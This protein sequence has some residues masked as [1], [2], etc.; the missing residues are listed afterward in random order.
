MLGNKFASDILERIRKIINA[1]IQVNCQV[2]LCRGINDGKELD[3][4]I[5]DLSE[6]YPGINSISIVPVGITR[7]RENLFK[8]EPYD[9]EAALGVIAQVEAWQNKL[10]ETKGSRVVYLADEFYILAGSELPGYDEYE[11]FPQLEN[12]VGLVTLF[13]HEFFMRLDK[14]MHKEKDSNENKEE[15]ED[16]NKEENRKKQ[17]LKPELPSA[18]GNFHRVLSVATGVLARK[19]IKE[20]AQELERIYNSVKI[21]VYPIKCS[22]FGEHVTV[23]GLLT[24][25]DIVKELSGKDLGREL[26][27]PATTLKSGSQVF[28]DDYTVKQ[29]ED[30]LG[31]R[32][33]VIEPN[34]KS[35]IDA[36]LGICTNI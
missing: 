17:E 19:F 15:N 18:P 14:M 31:I 8:L 32:V 11:G 20:L 22:F 30:M 26:L 34:G 10:L 24:G 16:G 21:N 35:F 29:V 9:R 25:Q 7:Y 4:T 3:N 28:L 1:G 27:I 36:V 13:K 23:A 5:K 33:R 12:G 6:L 2:V